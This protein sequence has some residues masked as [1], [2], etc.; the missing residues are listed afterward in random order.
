MAIPSLVAGT[1]TSFK[2]ETVGSAFSNAY[3]S[4]ATGTN[5]VLAV[6]I[7]YEQNAGVTIGSATYNGV[8]L[9]QKL[10]VDSSTANLADEDI[11]W[12]LL[13]NPATGSN[14]L[15]INVTSTD[16]RD[17]IALVA[18]F[19]DADQSSI[20][21]ATNSKTG[22]TDTGGVDETLSLTTTATNSLVLT[23]AVMD[24]F[25]SGTM[26]AA[27]ADTLVVNDAVAASSSGC[28]GAMV[29]QNAATVTSYTTGF[30]ADP[31]VA[32]AWAIASVELLEASSGNTL[33]A[34][35]GSYTFTGT[36]AALK[37]DRQL[38]AASGTYSYTGTNASL[39]RDAS[40][41]AA[42]G[43]YTYTGTD[44]ALTYSS[45]A[46]LAADSG[47]YVF[48]GT[49]VTLKAGRQ[50]SAAS[51][52]YTFTGTAAS[53]SAGRM[54]SA[55]SGTYLFT[56]T[57]AALK[58]ARKLAAASGSYLF[59]GTAATLTYSNASIW[60]A[61]TDDGTLWSVATDDGTAWTVQ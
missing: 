53:L 40:I 16:N 30:N 59:T 57:S 8:A 43:T 1:A 55:A 26:S 42:S 38:A 21:G 20:T 19:Q 9:T 11:D 4:G 49:S 33:T 28:I 7:M 52:S 47:S 45:G 2:T 56:G 10:H 12:W 35:S 61:Q 6:A 5:R 41:A 37:A 44:V 27:A 51:G 36:A 17:L 31:A 29:S 23:A 22:D 54:L 58:V 18:T 50:L 13:A 46:T 48:T 3:D 15:T 39:K 34:E 14:T 24:S 25:N 32:K 60:T